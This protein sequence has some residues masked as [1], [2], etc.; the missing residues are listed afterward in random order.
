MY[1]GWVNHTSGG[2]DVLIVLYCIVLVLLYSNVLVHYPAF[3]VY[4]G[5]RCLGHHF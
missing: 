4:L 3:I 1:C 5:V 2:G